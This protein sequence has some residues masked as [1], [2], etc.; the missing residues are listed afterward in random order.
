[1][2]LSIVSQGVFANGIKGMV[3]AGDGDGDN[4][5]ETYIVDSAG[6]LWW[7]EEGQPLMQ[8]SETG[9]FNYAGLLMAG[10]ATG[11]VFLLPFIPPVP[12]D[13]DADGDVDGADFVTW[14]THFP[15]SSG[16][17]LAQGDA[18]GDGDVDGADFVVWQT[19]FPFTASAG[20]SPIPEPAA[21]WLC[22]AAM[23][24]MAT[25]SSYRSRRRQP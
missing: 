24:A 1:V 10:G 22:V 21:V 23:L 4:I 9:D 3:S 25:R 16:A 13:F 18:D 14:Q 12:G 7:G 19:N 17:T 6:T 2:Q 8:V 20:A 5:G 11:E 15:T